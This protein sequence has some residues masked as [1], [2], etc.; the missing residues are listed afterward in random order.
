MYLHVGKTMGRTKTAV[1]NALHKTS[2]GFLIAFTAVTTGYLGYKAAYWFVGMNFSTSLT[3]QKPFPAH[4]NETLLI[5]NLLLT[6]KSV[7][8][9]LWFTIDRQYHQGWHLAVTQLE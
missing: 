9:G 7:H 3:A 5:C 1:Y 2:V 6:C 8:V 4:C